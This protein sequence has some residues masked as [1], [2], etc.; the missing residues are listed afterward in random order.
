MS[1]TNSAISGATAGASVGGPWGAAIGGAAG[2]LMGKDD[3]SSDYY[4]QMLKEAQGI[5]LPVLK[6]MHPELYKEIVSMNP[7]LETAV[8][9]GPSASEGITLDPQH[10]QAQQAALQSLMDITANDG[11]DARFQADAQRLQNDVNQNLQGNSQAIQQNMAMRGMSGGMS[12]MV[13]RQM[14][15]QQGANRQA[16]MEM[17]LNAQAQERALNALMNQGQLAGSMQ[18]NDFNRQN[19]IAGQ[20]DSISRFNAQNQQQVM[21][22]NVGYK[23]NAQQWNAQNKQG[24]ANQN[25]DL[26]NQAQQHNNNLG[27]QQY[28]NE[29]RKKGMINNAHQWNAQNSSNQAQYQ[30]QYVGNLIDSGATAYAANKRKKQD[31]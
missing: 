28:E 11:R 7:E 18:Q 5:P 3:K 27:Q 19:A 23:N 26:N 12:E 9:L 17:D 24:I 14:N 25:V 1:K 4:E 21:S 22:N 20:K 13:N 8:T 10:A 30:D 29:L 15:A 2:F 6:E 31:V 16:Q